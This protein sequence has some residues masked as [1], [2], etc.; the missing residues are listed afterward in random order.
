MINLITGDIIKLAESGKFDYILQGCNCFHTMGSGLAGQ[1]VKKYPLVL[2]AD[3]TTVYGDRE[4]LGTWT[5]TR[6]LSNHFQFTIVNV[7]TQ[8]FFGMGTDVFE[9]DCFD[10]FLKNFGEYLKTGIIRDRK[11]RVAFPKIG[12]GL[13]GGDWARILQ[14]ISNF[15]V[16]TSEFVDVTIVNYEND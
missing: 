8:F 3:K 13:A 4:K 5:S 11:I 12:A 14:S 15:S 10:E 2:A 16:S 9:Y 7:Y 6:I 1:L